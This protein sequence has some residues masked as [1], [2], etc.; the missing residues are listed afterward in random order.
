MASPAIH[1]GHFGQGNGG[2]GEG[3]VVRFFKK[4]NHTK[5]T[6]RH[7]DEMKD[8]IRQ[9]VMCQQA[10]AHRATHTSQ[11]DGSSTCG[12]E[13]MFDLFGLFVSRKDAEL[14]GL[15]VPSRVPHQRGGEGVKG[16]EI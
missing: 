1:R 6:E 7:T 2:L 3:G 13:N 16:D 10:L 5:Y 12:R 15:S 9:M 11:I 8:R 14:E 4:T